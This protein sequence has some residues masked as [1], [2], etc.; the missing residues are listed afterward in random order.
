MKATRVSFLNRAVYNIAQGFHHHTRET[1][2]CTIAVSILVSA[3]LVP[4][5]SYAT[6]IIFTEAEDSHIEWTH[7]ILQHTSPFGAATKIITA[8]NG[9]F[10]TYGLIKF[11]DIFGS[12]LDQVSAGETIASAE[13]HLWMSRE[14]SSNYFPNKINVYQLITDWDESTVTGTNYGGLYDGPVNNTTGTQIDSYNTTAPVGVPQEITFDVTASLLDWQTVGGATNFGWGI[15]SVNLHNV[16]YFYSSESGGDYTPYLVVNS[17]TSP[18]PEPSILALIFTG[19]FGLG[20]ARRR[21]G[22]R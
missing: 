11:D 2:N 22:K 10:D 6:P 7:G 16:N 19:L 3:L 8:N 4:T 14:T 20:L 5:F 13:L 1:M 15:E 18:I 9:I 21:S 17:S 12:A